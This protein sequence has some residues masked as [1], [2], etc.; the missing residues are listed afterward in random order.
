VINGRL[1]FV[2]TYDKAQKRRGNTEYVVRFLPDELS[3]IWAQYLVYV[4]PFAQVVEYEI[5]KALNHPEYLFRD[6][7]GPWAG[8]ELTQA[9]ASATEKHLSVRLT[10]SEWRHVAI[11]IADWHLAAASK[12]WDRNNDADDDKDDNFAEGGDED[13]LELATLQHI[14]VRYVRCFVME[15]LILRLCHVILFHFE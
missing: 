4:R 8:E 11:G 5:T 9:L 2:T 3:Q 14:V 1:A 15:F 10:S 12:S 6:S 13:E 7:R